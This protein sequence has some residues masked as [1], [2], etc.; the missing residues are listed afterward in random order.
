MA[1]TRALNNQGEPSAESS[2]Q[3]AVARGLQF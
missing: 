1:E 3:G 2:I